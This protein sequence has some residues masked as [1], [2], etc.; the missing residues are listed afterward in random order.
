[1]GINRDARLGRERVE[2]MLDEYLRAY[3]PAPPIA[4]FKGV[5]RDIE[6]LHTDLDPNDPEQMR[7]IRLILEAGLRELQEVLFGVQAKKRLGDGA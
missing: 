3:E 7:R 4:R 5:D 1:M 2:V 6:V